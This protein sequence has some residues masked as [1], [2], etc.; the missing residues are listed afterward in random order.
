MSAQQFNHSTTESTEIT[1]EHGEFLK[2]RVVIILPDN[3]EKG[4]LHGEKVASSLQGI[5]TCIRVVKLPNLPEKGDASDWIAA[6]GTKEQLAT[7]RFD[8]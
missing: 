7:A 1:E 5:A 2:D 3:D 6:G 8:F 4:R